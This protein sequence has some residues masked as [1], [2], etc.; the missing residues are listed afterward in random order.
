MLRAKILARG[1]EG[2][3]YYGTNRFNLRAFWPRTRASSPCI[4]LSMWPRWAARRQQQQ[5]LSR[6]S[7]VRASLQRRP[8][9]SARSY[10][11]VMIKLHYNWK[12]NFL[13]PSMEE[14]VKRYNEKFR[15][16]K[17][18]AASTSTAAPAMAAPAPAPAPAPVWTELLATIYPPL[19]L[20]WRCVV[21]YLDTIIDLHRKHSCSLSF[22]FCR[23]P[24]LALSSVSEW[25]V[26]GRSGAW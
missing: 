11:S 12:Y 16:T 5:K 15:P 23:V 18:A 21:L 22:L 25:C 13:R 8:S 26:V 4:M 17:A 10:S 20:S 3:Y 14:I 6:S 19:S 1:T 24:F 2:E 7:R 9:R